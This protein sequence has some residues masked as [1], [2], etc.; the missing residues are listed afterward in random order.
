MANS[1]PK[2][3]TP[4]TPAMPVPQRKQMAA[5]GSPVGSSPKTPA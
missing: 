4:P 5:G 2:Q 1:V 3:Q